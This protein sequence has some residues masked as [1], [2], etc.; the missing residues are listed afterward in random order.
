[1]NSQDHEFYSHLKSVVGAVLLVFNPLSIKTLSNLLRNCYT[2]SGMSKALHALHSLLLVPESTEDPVCAFHKSFPDF[3]TDPQRCTDEQFFV[4]PSVHHTELLLSCLAL[5]KGGL[6]KNICHLDDHTIL[7]EVEDLST[8]LKVHIGDALEYACQFWANHLSRI[9]SKDSETN[10]VLEAI[11]EFF[12]NRLLFWIEVLSLTKNLNAGIYA[13]SNVQQ[14]CVL[15]SCIWC[16]HSSPH[17]RPFRQELPT[18]GRT[19]ASG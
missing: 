17:S 3:L 6:K 9:P 7:S 1:V 16:F 4:N 10:D 2:P 8:H 5:M 19:T 18:T 13:L 11:G 12:A 14:W 15:V